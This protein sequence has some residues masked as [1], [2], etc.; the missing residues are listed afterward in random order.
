MEKKIYIF[1]LFTLSLLIG[2]ILFYTYVFF[3]GRSG[4]YHSSNIIEV[5]QL[6]SEYYLGPTIDANKDYISNVEY[7]IESK[8]LCASH[9]FFFWSCPKLPMAVLPRN[10]MAATFLAVVVR[11][12]RL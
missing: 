12:S 9:F 10:L 7:F 11:D 2:T 6:S 5:E 1:T 8:V 4:N 3:N